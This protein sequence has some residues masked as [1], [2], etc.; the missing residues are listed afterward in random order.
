MRALYLVIWN[1]AAFSDRLPLKSSY[2]TPASKASFCSGGSGWLV[3]VVE[4]SC[5]SDGLNEVL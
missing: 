5:S 3:P 1:S 2:F 4:T